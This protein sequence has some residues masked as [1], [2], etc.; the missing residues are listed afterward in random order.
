MIP[1][2]RKCA[3]KNLAVKAHGDFPGSPVAKT[4]CFQRIGF[5]FDPWWGT[6]IPHATEHDQTTTIKASKQ[7]YLLNN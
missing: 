3:V 5:N 6:R 2:H 4:L 7:N 1:I